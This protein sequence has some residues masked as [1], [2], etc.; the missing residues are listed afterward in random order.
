M[1]TLKGA[2]GQA[3]DTGLLVNTEWSNGVLRQPPSIVDLDLCLNLL[4]LNLAELSPFLV[5]VE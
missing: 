1:K 5:E 2:L 4:L 3:L